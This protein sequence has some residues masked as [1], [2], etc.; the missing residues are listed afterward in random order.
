MRGLH[1]YLGE[2]RLLLNALDV[3][4]HS[5]GSVPTYVPLQALFATMAMIN[6]EIDFNADTVIILRSPNTSFAPWSPDGVRGNTIAHVDDSVVDEPAV[7]DADQ[8]TSSQTAPVAK[9]PSQTTPVDS[10][11]KEEEIRYSVSRRHLISVSPMFKRMLSEMNW[12]EGIR[13]EDD[14]LHHV[15]TKDWDS[16]ALLHVLQVIHHRNREV[17]RIV[18]LE[19]LAKIAVLID[20]YECAEAME[21]F[22]E[23]WTEHLLVTSPVPSYFCRDLLLWMCIAWVLKLPREF[24]L[25]TTVAIRADDQKLPTLGL[26]IMICIGELAYPYVL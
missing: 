16:Q 7:A 8:E 19:M 4:S 22:T 1:E 23:R 13:D 17:P 24:A 11:I 20:F 12:K 26:P 10:G 15:P 25:T 2:A 21:S 18:S 5:P 3:E 9:G 6:H 14:G